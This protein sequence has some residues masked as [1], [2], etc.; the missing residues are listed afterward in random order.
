MIAQEPFCSVIIVNYNGKRFLDACLESVFAQTYPAFEVIVVDNGSTDGSVEF[1]RSRFPVARVVQAS[2]NLGFA[3][4][5]NLGVRHA[6]GNT[7]ILL[8]NDTVVEEGWMRELVETVNRDGV[9]IASSL[10]LTEGIPGRYFERNG[11]INFLGHNIMRVFE[12]PENIFFGGGASLAYRSEVLGVPFDPDYFAYGE[13]VYLSLRARF[14]GMHVLHTNASVVRH[15]GSGTAGRKRSAFMAMHQEKNR[16]MNI[17]LFF[18]PVTLIKIAPFL[19][20]NVFAKLIVCL[21][22]SRCSLAGILRAYAWLAGHGGEIW[23]KRQ[24]LRA[25]QR[26]GDSDVISWMSAHLTNGETPPGS[27]VNAMARAY[28]RLVRLRTVE[29]LPKGS[30]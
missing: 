29:A 4:G 17:L 14:Q 7:I 1:L 3:E 26:V 18:S 9:A 23:K 8:N 15:A 10:I 11:S 2:H 27:L 20:G 28:C 30:R 5:N 12:R 21:L 16:L 19:A 24:S 13:D 6:K 22:S 25:E